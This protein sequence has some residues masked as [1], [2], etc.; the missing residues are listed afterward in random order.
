MR[1]SAEVVAK[2]AAGNDV[3]WLSPPRWWNMTAAE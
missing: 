3:I 1:H 2:L